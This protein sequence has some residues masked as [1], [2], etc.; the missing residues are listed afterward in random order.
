MGLPEYAYGFNSPLTPD[1]TPDEFLEQFAYDCVRSDSPM[2]DQAI[3][4]SAMSE[5]SGRYRPPRLPSSVDDF[6]PENEWDFDDAAIF[7]ATMR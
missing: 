5:S 6:R 2:S 1:D 3:F 4:A 7:A